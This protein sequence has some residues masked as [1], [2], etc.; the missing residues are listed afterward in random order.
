[1]CFLQIPNDFYHK[2]PSFTQTDKYQ[3]RMQWLHDA[4]ENVRVFDTIFVYPFNFLFVFLQELQE[5]LCKQYDTFGS[6]ARS[7]FWTQLA[8]IAPREQFIVRCVLFDDDFFLLCFIISKFLLKLC[9]H[10]CY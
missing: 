2:T 10:I 1:V 4:G 8:D 7:E 3:Q 5:F 6:F 9:L